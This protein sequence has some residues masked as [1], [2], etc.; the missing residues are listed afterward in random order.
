MNYFEIKNRLDTLRKFRGL[1]I[2]ILKTSSRHENKEAGKILTEL[3]PLT[4]LT[5]NSLIKI[6]QGYK[7]IKIE[8]DFS[9]KR[10]RIN[11]FRAIFRQKL[12]RR[13]GLDEKAPLK[14]LDSA[15]AEYQG[16]LWRQKIQ[17][18]NPLF[19]IITFVDFALGIPLNLLGRIF[20]RADFETSLPARLYLAAGQLIVFLYLADFAGLFGWLRWDLLAAILNF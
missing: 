7:M 18:F 3:R 10:I 17:L 2:Q 1:Y 6:G 19:W 5:M 20:P 14:V 13:Y 8:K 9:G 12:Q 11:I 16:N 4:P 15:I